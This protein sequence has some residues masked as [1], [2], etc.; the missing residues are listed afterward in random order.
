[1]SDTTDIVMGDDRRNVTNRGMKRFL[2]LF[3][4]RQPNLNGTRLCDLRGI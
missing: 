1:M 4:L 2:H 3:I